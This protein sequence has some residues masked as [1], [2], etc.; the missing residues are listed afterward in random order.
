[1][2]EL[3]YGDSLYSMTVLMPTDFNEPLDK[4]VAEKINRENLEAWRADLRVPSRDVI[5]ELPK[6]ELEYELNYNDI[7]KS[8][9]MVV[10]FEELEADFGG[11]AELNGQNL[12]ISEVKH[13]TFVKVDETGTEAAAVTSVGVGVTSMPPSVIV[14]RPF[15][16]IISER[17]SGV[18]LFMGKVKNPVI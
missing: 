12:F 17:S 3:P 7:L 2:I 15:V 14:N 18:N 4:F 5:L 8:M 16:F 6:F 10:P 9:G 13:K 11:I 1:M